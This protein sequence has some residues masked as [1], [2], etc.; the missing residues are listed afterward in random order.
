MRNTKAMFLQNGSGIVKIGQ[1]LSSCD[2]DAWSTKARVK[3]FLRT[4]QIVLQ[5]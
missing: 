4:K 1:G 3:Y 2:S 5:I